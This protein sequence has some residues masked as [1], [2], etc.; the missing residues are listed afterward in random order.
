MCD[1]LPPPPTSSFAP[2]RF[3]IEVLTSGCPFGPRGGPLLYSV[4]ESANDRAS[5]QA[6]SVPNNDY[7]APRRKR[8]SPK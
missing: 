6:P 3:P 4:G 2:P 7:T 5:K 8:A 1:E